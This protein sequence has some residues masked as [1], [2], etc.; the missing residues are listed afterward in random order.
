[1][2]GTGLLGL[3]AFQRVR[4]DDVNLDRI[5]APAAWLGSVGPGD[6][7]HGDHPGRQCRSQSTDTPKLSAGAGSESALIDESASGGNWLGNA[8]SSCVRAVSTAA[9]DVEVTL[10]RRDA[11]MNSCQ[12]TGIRTRNE[13]L[14]VGV[15]LTAVGGF[16]DAYTFV[17]HAVFANAQTGNI[18][19]FGVETASRHWHA[20]LL[21]LVPIAAFMVGVVATETLGRPRVRRRVRR[22]LRVALG[23][24]IVILAAVASLPNGAPALLV[25]V[26]V[27]FAAS[28]QWTTF[29]MLVDAPYSTLL[30]TGNLRTATV[31]TFQWIMDHDP[32]ARRHAGHFAAVV[33]AFVAGAIIGAICTNNFGTPAVAIAAGVLLITLAGLIY[34]TRQLE[35]RAA[36]TPV[37]AGAEEPA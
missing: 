19:L 14:V 37:E 33:A 35:R 1:V 34:E 21:R 9:V 4:C 18:V 29:R 22:P 31:S 24:E 7:R 28:I 6:L 26:P 30:A 16:L 25:T 23:A 8:F 32:I 15:W 10:E 3:N 13:N 2:E 27:A 5:T 11:S 36:N 20:A 17:G 12:M